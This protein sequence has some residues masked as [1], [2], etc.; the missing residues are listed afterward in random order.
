MSPSK[1]VVSYEVRNLEK[2]RH[3]SILQEAGL[4]IRREI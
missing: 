3:S 1:E 2:R 4:I